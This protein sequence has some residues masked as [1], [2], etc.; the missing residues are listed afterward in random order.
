MQKFSNFG[1]GPKWCCAFNA[2]DDS[3]LKVEIEFEKVN[4]K[5]LRARA[6]NVMIIIDKCI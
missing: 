3:V 5:E 1:S 2:G 4:E 6:R